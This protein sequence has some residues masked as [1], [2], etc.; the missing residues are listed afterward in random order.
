MKKQQKKAFTLVELLVV[1]AILAILA[2]VAVVGY[3]AFIKNAA[4]SNDENVV[5]QMNRYLEALKAD[6]ASDYYNV[7]IHAGNVKQL[8]AHILQESGMG[9]LEPAAEKYGY[10]FYFNLEDGEYVVKRNQEAYDASLLTRNYLRG[11]YVHAEGESETSRYEKRLENCF[12]TNNQ[13]FLVDTLG[14]LAELINSV[15]NIGT[16]AEGATKT[17]SGE[18]IDALIDSLAGTELHTFV[19]VNVVIVTEGKNYR[20]NSE[21]SEGEAP[22]NV[23]VLSG[24]TFINTHT[25][26][27]N[28]NGEWVDVENVEK[29]AE[30]D[31]LTLPETV[32]AVEKDALKLADNAEIYTDKSPEELSTISN[33]SFTDANIKSKDGNTYK[34][35]TDG[36]TNTEDETLHVYNYAYGL[37]NITIENGDSVAVTP[38]VANK[39]IVIAGDITVNIPYEVNSFT[40]HLSLEDNREENSTAPVLGQD[41]IAWST[42]DTTK[43][44][45][46]YSYSI[47]NQTLTVS[48]KADQSWPNNFTLTASSNGVVRNFVINVEDI[49]AGSVTFNG[50]DLVEGETP[51]MTVI[52]SSSENITYAIAK[53]DYTYTHNNLGVCDDTIRV[54]YDGTGATVDGTNLVATSNGSGTLTIT[55]GSEA[56]TYLTYTVNLTIADTSNFAVQP[57]N[58]NI[59][60]VGNGNAVNVSE[61]FKLNANATIPEGAELVVF[62]GGSYNG[63]TYMTPN[64]NELQATEGADPGL[65]VDSPGQK[66]T[67]DNFNTLTLDFDGADANN[68][69]RL[70]VMHNGVRISEDVIVKVVDGYNVRNYTDLTSNVNTTADK[71]GNYSYP[72]TSSVVFLDNITMSGE[73]NFLQIPAGKTLYGNGFKFDITAGR[74][75]EEGIINLKGT[76]RDVMVVGAVYSKFSFSAGDDYGSSAVNATGSAYIYNSYIANTRSPLRT[77]GAGVVIE[78]SVLFGGRYSNIDMTGGTITIRGTVTTVQQVYSVAKE[79]NGGTAANNVIGMGVSA[80]FNDGK[81]NVVIEEGANLVQYNFMD[82]SI[83]QYLPQLK[84]ASIYEVMDLKEPFNAMFNDTATYGNYMYTAANGKT[85]ANSGI[86]STDKYMLNYT[87]G[88]DSPSGTLIKKYAVGAKK[89]V[90]A[91]T[92]NIDDNE[93]FIIAYDTRLTPQVGTVKSAGYVEVT[94]AQL[95]AGVEF[96]V[97]TAINS[98]ANAIGYSFQIQSDNYLTI[99]VSGEGST[100]KYNTITYNFDKDLGGTLGTVESILSMHDRGI[101]YGKMCV[102]VNTPVSTAYA[103]GTTTYQQLLEQYI[104]MTDGDGVG[105]NF[106]TPENFQFVNG[107]V[108]NYWD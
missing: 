68:A 104:E 4:V 71:N 49:T 9:E 62:A 13:Y 58:K 96:K 76:L 74:K 80:W 42:D 61:L 24:V 105:D 46:G 25:Q 103:Y 37:T 84:V 8:T 39:D 23:I 56:H 34:A 14:S 57:A 69:I 97:T 107:S 45:V 27:K 12:T 67:K 85:Y 47:T 6:S 81:K 83:S 73:V 101:H 79:N 95:K 32:E 75:K 18:E 87:I 92:P 54:A 88:G 59:T 21:D 26:T 72:L 30:T 1:I 29:L 78:D 35:G 77:S 99:N 2:S 48:L 40:I 82:S 50:T 98:G 36:I 51:N 94:G 108:S 19:S 52:T 17:V 102:G 43:S 63:D 89:I 91:T 44:A 70:A 66:I 31:K 10:N 15:Y 90:T 20:L 33:G 106:Y 64:R 86:V 22:D 65:S 41:T 16:D 53:G 3:T 93:S 7:E 38:A 11:I 28:E 5:A 60:V 100:D 55:V